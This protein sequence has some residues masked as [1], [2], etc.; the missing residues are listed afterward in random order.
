M[1]IKRPLPSPLPR[2]GNELRIE[3]FKIGEVFLRAC[4]HKYDT[5]TN[6]RSATKGGDKHETRNTKHEIK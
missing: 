6:Q 3:F 5:N 4:K 2:R 1:C